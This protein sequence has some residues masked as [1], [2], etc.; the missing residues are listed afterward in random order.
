MIGTYLHVE[1]T[2]TTGFTFTGAVV[3][4]RVPLPMAG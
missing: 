3:P 4:E 1:I 2:G